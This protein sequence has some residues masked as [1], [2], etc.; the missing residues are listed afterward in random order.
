MRTELAELHL[1]GLVNGEITAGHGQQAECRDLQHFVVMGNVYSS[2]PVPWS[3][4]VRIYVG[5]RSCGWPAV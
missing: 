2:R 3:H 1:V 4:V 5:P